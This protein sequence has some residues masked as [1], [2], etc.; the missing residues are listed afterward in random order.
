MSHVLPLT[1]ASA[2]ASRTPREDAARL[3]HRLWQRAGGQAGR[4]VYGPA[5]RRVCRIDA[6][7]FSALT[8]SLEAEGRLR[9]R[10]LVFLEV[11]SAGIDAVLETAP[12]R[13]AFEDAE[14][15]AELANRESDEE[16]EAEYERDRA[17]HA[18]AGRAGGGMDGEMGGPVDGGLAPAASDRADAQRTQAAGPLSL[19]PTLLGALP[20][21]PDGWEPQPHARESGLPQ[22]VSVA[23]V[24]HD[25]VLHDPISHDPVLPGPISHDPV[26]P[27]PALP[28]AASP[29]PG[30]LSYGLAGAADGEEAS[31]APFLNP[32]SK[33][34]L[35]PDLNPEPAAGLPPD[36]APELAPD[37]QRLC[38]AI[39]LAPAQLAPAAPAP[40][41]RAPAIPPPAIPVVEA[42]GW[43]GPPAPAPVLSTEAATSG[44][45]LSQDGGEIA[46][47]LASLMLE[48]PR[49]GLPDAEEAEAEAEITTCTAQLLSPR[50]K[51]AIVVASLTALLGLL[52]GFGPRMPER[53]RAAALE[54]R[55]FLAGMEP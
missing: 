25:P 18:G 11:T 43:P 41:M 39:G 54:L 19:G 50:P 23:P 15:A 4:L 49:L 38:Q 28:G 14:G 26:L 37:L 48:L 46:R 31:P 45:A 6:V 21:G 36:L 9:R 34:D 8:A 20:P 16:E 7:T 44:G 10:L 55:L 17:R 42:P 22:P 33:P 2:A 40:A 32:G 24:L 1:D 52:E 30:P 35:K 51:P 29:V 13:G 3:L 53:V 27:G 47:T 12:W 5:L